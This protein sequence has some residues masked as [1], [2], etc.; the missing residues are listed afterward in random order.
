MRIIIGRMN[1]L[2]IARLDPKGAF[3]DG[4]A[5]G[6]L[7]LPLSQLPA[8]P[9]PG[10][11]AEVFCYLDDGKMTVTARRPRLLAGEAGRLAVKD[12]TP[13]AAYLDWGI[14]KDL[15]IPFREQDGPL[16]PGETIL[17]YAA[18]DREGRIFATQKFDRHIPE[19]LPKGSPLGAGSPVGLTLIARAPLGW[20]ALVSGTCY[21][22]LPAAEAAAI[23]DP[24]PGR[25]LK[26]WISSVRRD[27]RVGVT[28]R[29]PGMAGVR[30]AEEF[31]LG[32]L[33]RAGGFLPYG[34]FSDPAAIERRFGMSKRKF[35]MAIGGLYRA[36][37][38]EPA[39]GGIRLVPGGGAGP[40]ADPE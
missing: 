1:T 34:D 26:G 21:G 32:E 8:D 35:K 37:R 2:R 25:R 7:F 36:R 13:G 19:T 23:A 3:L 9:A 20:K 5:A 27:F 15:M 14:R 22:L 10:A 39:E 12:V 4:G 29:E 33:G 24:V 6:E 17:V 11:A 28:L 16:R 18:V 30:S 31:L 40:A 38:A